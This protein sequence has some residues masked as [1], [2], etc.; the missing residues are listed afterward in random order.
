MRP[1]IV[2]EETGMTSK[3]Y[4]ISVRKTDPKI[5]GFSNIFL[6]SVQGHRRDFTIDVGRA[7][8][9]DDLWI[10]KA[11]IRNIKSTLLSESQV[12]S[13]VVPMELTYT[14]RPVTEDGE[15]DEREGSS[16]PPAQKKPI[17]GDPVPR[18][19]FVPRDE[20]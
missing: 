19:M 9:F 3:Q 20:L 13:T 16:N 17:K 1:F 14:L 4:V 7:M 18:H 8:I 12:E 2:L 5:G 6:E 15:P 10:V 11:T